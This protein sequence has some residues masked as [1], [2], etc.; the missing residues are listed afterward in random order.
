MRSGRLLLALLVVLPS[1]AFAQAATCSILNFGIFRN[2][3]TYDTRQAPGT[4]G[5]REVL[6]HPRASIQ[7]TDRVPGKLGVLFGVVHRFEGIPAG[8]I[9]AAVIRH[10]PLPT[11]G[12]GTITESMLPKEPE[13]AATGFRFDRLDEVVPGEW[14]F[15][16]QHESHV[17]CRKAFTVE[18][19]D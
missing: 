4:A 8:S 2:V 17:L 1:A 14:I 6:A 15:E 19:A 13:S 9:V 10:P 18:K 7:Q 16:F 3:E 12:G 5:G 11:P